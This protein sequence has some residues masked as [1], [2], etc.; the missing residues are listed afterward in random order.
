MQFFGE[1]YP[2]DRDIREDIFEEF[3]G[4]FG[5]DAM[6]VEIEE[7]SGGFEVA[8]DNYANQG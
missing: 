3:Y 8:A 1:Q 7:E 4:K 5:E 2:R 6:A